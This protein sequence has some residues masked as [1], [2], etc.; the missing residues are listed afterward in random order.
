MAKF[1]L[2]L[3]NNKVRQ[4][5]RIALFTIIINLIVFIAWAKYTTSESARYYSIIGAALVIAVLATETLSNRNKNKPTAAYKL[6]AMLLVSLTWLAIGNWWMFAA[7]LLLTWLY[8]ASKRQLGVV[9]TDKQITYPSFPKKD[10]QWQ[11]LSNL[12]LK[13]GLLTIDFK[14]NKILQGEIIP[15]DPEVNEKEFNEFCSMQLSSTR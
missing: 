5:D 7:S 15:A 13:D 12:I 6:V 10:I 2:V 9:V 8:H 14:S 4:Y 3:K 11:E 1:E